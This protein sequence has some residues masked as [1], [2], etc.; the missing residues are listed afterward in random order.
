MQRPGPRARAGQERNA[1]AFDQTNVARA[2]TFCRLLRGE[3]H[4][5]AFAQQL[6]HGATDRAPVEEVLDA[7]F[8]ADEPKAL[9]DQEASNCPGRHNP[10]PPFRTPRE[11][12]R[13]LRR[14]PA[15]GVVHTVR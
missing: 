9:V 5:L 6:E 4:A 2:R 7:A 14:A 1:S 8:V 11:I 12:P 15:K 3:L 13:E 10:T